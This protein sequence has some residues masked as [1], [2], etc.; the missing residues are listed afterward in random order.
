MAAHKSKKFKIRVH[1]G[2]KNLNKMKV[3]SKLKQ[4]ECNRQMSMN[5]AI[6]STVVKSEFIDNLGKI[7]TWPSW[8]PGSRVTLLV[9][10]PD[11]RP[12]GLGWF[13]AKKVHPFYDTCQVEVFCNVAD[14]TIGT[15]FFL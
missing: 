4:K 3:K 14:S 6:V 11:G 13:L 9:G 10:R 5:E 2:S 1:E 7:Q 8:P 15:S 12:I